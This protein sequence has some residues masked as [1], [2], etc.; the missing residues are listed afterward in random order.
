MWNSDSIGDA[1]GVLR[2]G[3]QSCSLLQ[4]LDGALRSFGSWSIAEYSAE[5]VLEQA[6]GEIHWTCMAIVGELLAATQ[7]AQAMA[8]F[9]K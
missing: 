7:S 4:N 6:W 5:Q 2:L 9:G 1:E 3:A 8:R